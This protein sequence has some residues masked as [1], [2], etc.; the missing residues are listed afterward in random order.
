MGIDRT[1]VYTISLGDFANGVAVFWLKVIGLRQCS[2]SVNRFCAKRKHFAQLTF[3]DS[4]KSL[5]NI[6]GRNVSLPYQPING[7]STDAKHGYRFVD[8]DI[9]S[10]LGYILHDVIQLAHPLLGGLSLVIG[11]LRAS[12][13]AVLRIKCLCDEC[14]TAILA[15]PFNLKLSRWHV[16]PF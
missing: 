8:R 4:C 2:T 14:I 3:A 9:I 10:G 6:D 7:I 16:V 13:R 15:L 11:P 5:P 12:S 1:V